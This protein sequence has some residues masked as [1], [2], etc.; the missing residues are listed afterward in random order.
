LFGPVARVVLGREVAALAAPAGEGVHDAVDDL[1]DAG[2]A[3]RAA[4]A[5]A[6]VLL[7]VDVDGELRPRAGD[8]DVLL[9]EDHLSLLAGA[10][11]GAALPRDQVVG[12]AARRREVALEPEPGLRLH[13]PFSLSPSAMVSVAAGGGSDVGNI[14][15]HLENASFIHPR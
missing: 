14:L 2:L 7:G 11:R 10:R 4:G 8:L 3:L 13:S 9:L 5:A 15:G 6:E 12:V 1:A